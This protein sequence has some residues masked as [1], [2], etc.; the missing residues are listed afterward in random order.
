MKRFLTYSMFAATALVAVAGSASAQNLK[1]EIPFAFRAGTALLQPGTYD[2][3]TRTAAASTMYQLRNRDTNESVMVFRQGTRDAAKAWLA[4]GRPTLA[5]R[6]SGTN[7]ALAEV[8]TGGASSS[9]FTAP[10]SAAGDP[11]RIA[12]VRMTAAKAD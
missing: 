4:A 6:C 7:C 9:F 3:V 12:E 2:V 1:A 10:K 11:V 5:F 8:W